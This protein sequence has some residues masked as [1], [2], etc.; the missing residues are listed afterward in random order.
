MNQLGQVVNA[1]V[2]LEN[3]DTPFQWI[4]IRFCEKIHYYGHIEMLQNR[5]RMGNTTFRQSY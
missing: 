3:F 5:Y 2:S 4:I 1:I